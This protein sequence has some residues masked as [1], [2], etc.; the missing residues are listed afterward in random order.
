VNGPLSIR[1]VFGP[2]AKIYARHALVLLPA[3]ACLTALITV[4]DRSPAR[5]GPGFAVAGLIVELAIVTLFTAMV[6]RL[7]ADVYERGEVRSIDQLVGASMP[8]FGQLMLVGFVASLVIGLLFSAMS[9]I[10]LALLIGAVV[11]FGVSVGSIVAGAGIGIV[12]FLAPG[13][14]LLTVW[15]VAAPV[16]VLERPG[17]LRALRRSRLLVRGNRLRVFAAIAMV[18]IPLGLADG[19]IELAG[20]AAGTGPDTIAKFLGATLIAPVPVLLATTLYY[21]LRRISASDL[22]S[23]QT[24]SSSPTDR[25]SPAT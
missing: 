13:L 6:V 15:S 20:H 8:M 21:E 25:P 16:V 23:P 9:F 14:F 7:A 11:N 24:R 10:M 22:P 3:A 18:A 1:A 2:T 4:L 12:L 19:G 17:G 5:G